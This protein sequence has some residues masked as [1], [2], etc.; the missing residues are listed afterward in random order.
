LRD[1]SIQRI[2]RQGGGGGLEREGKRTHFGLENGMRLIRRKR[3]TR[4]K[5]LKRKEEKASGLTRRET[6]EKEERCHGAASKPMVRGMTAVVCAE[7]SN[8]R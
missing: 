6:Y 3:L 1:L 7:R 8:Q 4:R 2:E 5:R